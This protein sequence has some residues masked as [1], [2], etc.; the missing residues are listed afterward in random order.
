MIAGMVA[1]ALVTF[2]TGI[3]VI[4]LHYRWESG[5]LLL[6]LDDRRLEGRFLDLGL[7]AFVVLLLGPLLTLILRWRRWETW[8]SYSLAFMAVMAILTECG[9]G[10]EGTGLAVV[11]AGAGGMVWWFIVRWLRVN[12]GRRQW[13]T[14]AGWLII[15][16][17]VAVLA[18]LIWNTARKSHE[19]LGRLDNAP[20]LG[21]ADRHELWLVRGDRLMRY[22]RSTWQ[23]Q[24]TGQRD[25]I[26]MVM[27][28]DRVWA[29]SVHYHYAAVNAAAS[30]DDVSRTLELVVYQGGARETVLKQLYRRGGPP[31]GMIVRDGRP[32]I[33]TQTAILG[34]LA[35]GSWKPM[36]L[37]GNANLSQMGGGGQAQARN[38]PRHLYVGN[39]GGEFFGGANRI[40]LQTGVVESIERRDR[41]DLCAGPL[42][43]ACDPV[44][45]MAQDPA[46]TDCVLATTYAPMSSTGGAILRLCGRRVEL[47]MQTPIMPI[48]RLVMRM[49]EIVANLAGAGWPPYS[50][51]ITEPVYAM[52]QTRDG[53]VWAVGKNALYRADRKGIARTHLPR[54]RRYGDLWIAEL[55][56]LLLIARR[57]ADGHRLGG[58]QT[59]LVPVQP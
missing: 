30:L 20:M 36:P 24:D 16:A 10:G 33:L 37:S 12:V 49:E 45:G 2:A 52:E 42:N 56:G 46:H 39:D 53:V 27:D 28:R 58:Y 19:D 43:R 5:W 34:Q 50:E 21:V 22:D 13:I 18:G 48:L 23:G 44:M 38:D 15:I 3:I 4:L 29:L 14:V 51:R 32:P 54:T 47:A 35:D 31:I 7:A 25:V 1:S 59:L 17:L 11:S 9:S 57:D 6:T 8:W 41:Q 26:S 55:P 40:D